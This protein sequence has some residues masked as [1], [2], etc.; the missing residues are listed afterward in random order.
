MSE[1][2][3]EKRQILYEVYVLKKEHQEKLSEEHL[4]AFIQ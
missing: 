2:I 3:E 4:Q 1:L